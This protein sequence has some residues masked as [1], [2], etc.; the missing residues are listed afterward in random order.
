[1][2][3]LLPL[4]LLLIFGGALVV[5]CFS[6]PALNRR[7]SITHLSWLLALVPMAAFIL[8]AS[9]VPGINDGQTFVWRFQWLPALGLELGLYFDGL[10]ALFALLVTF[11]GTLIV[12]YSGGYFKGDQTAWRFLTYMLL[13]MGSM[14]GLVM[15]GDILTLFIFWEGTS[16]TSYLLIAYKTKDESARRGGFL[17][18]FIT[19]GGGIALLAGLLMVSYVAGDTS[20][21]A[22]LGQGDVLRSHDLYLVMLGLV[23][24]GAFTKSAQFPAHIWLP[25]AMSAPTPASA[26]LHSATMVKAGI[27]LLARLNPALGLTESWFWLLTVVGMLTM[28]TGAYL[29]LKQNDLKALLA[30][31]TISQLGIL[32]ILIGQDNKS[33]FKALVIGVTAHALYKSALFLAAGIVDHETGTR[34]LRRLGGLRKS[35]PI[36]FFMTAIAALSMAGLPPLFGFLAKET[37]LVASL[38]PSLPPFISPIFTIATV[39]AGA[40]MLGM[41]GMLVWDT[42]IRRPRD[43]SVRSHEAPPSMLLALAFPALLSLIIGLLPGPKEEASLLAEAA[44]AAFG[45]PVEVS[46]TLWHGLTT[47][48]ALSIVAISLGLI[49]FFFRQP[50]RDLQVRL[51]PALSFGAVYDWVLLAIDRLSYGATR[52]QQGRLRVYLAV[53][54]VGTVLLTWVLSGTSWLKLDLVGVNW[55]ALSFV[56]ETRLLQLFALLMVVGAAMATIVLRRDF[57]AIMAMGLAGLSVAI[58]FIL[59]P[60]PDVALVQIVVDILAMVIL[61]LALNRLPRQQRRQAQAITE[62]SGQSRASYLRDVVIAVAVGLTVTMLAFIA[63]TSRPRISAATPYYEENAKSLTGATDIVGA[64]VVDFR[65][66]DTLLEI[67]VFSVAGLGIFTLLRYAAQKA[68]DSV[69]ETGPATARQPKLKTRGIGG[70]R[71]SPFIRIPAYAILPLSMV[72]AATHMMYGHDQ[73]GDG[74]TA[75]VIVGLA[76]GLWYIVFGY[77]ETR[78]RLSWLK[79]P[80][81]ISTGLLLAIVTGSVAAA[82]NGSFLSNFDF[83]ERLGLPLPAGFHISTSFLFE[84]AICLTVLGS[85]AYML[86]TLGHPADKDRENPNV[87][88]ETKQQVR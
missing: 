65:S 71:I 26:Y 54:L 55:P 70:L 21:V 29:G 1:M 16:I 18:L 28:L 75:G 46:L 45:Q 22:I 44:T 43:P 67:A 6:Q 36:T 62:N 53:I 60:A 64:I 33:G 77:E 49:I 10:S 48:L 11:I 52:L 58:L 7:L 47:E 25:R 39:V 51:W 19:G 4:P 76:V 81:L 88:E 35:M 78:Q 41:A 85:L 32:V 87:Y 9:L 23:A 40:L 80:I 31:S 30:Y 59:E 17:A 34:D 86:N 66:L 84:V 50:I 79:A 57:S 24:F 20:F 8:L 56:S 61:V 42:F 37:L 13:F 72:L 74:F 68:G 82:V 38:H 2:N 5:A 14:L 63:L 15:A 69:P 3:Q 12:I 83:G 27:F 73:P